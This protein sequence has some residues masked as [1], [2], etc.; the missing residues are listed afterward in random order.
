M[1]WYQAAVKGPSL[2][3]RFRHSATLVDPSHVYY[4]GGS[5][6]GVL[7]NDIAVLDLDQRSLALATSSP[8]PPLEPADV[9]ASPPYPHKGEPEF[10]EVV[11]VREPIGITTLDGMGEPPID[12]EKGEAETTAPSQ[13]PPSQFPALPNGQVPSVEEVMKMYVGMAMALRS[14]RQQRERMEMSL[15]K[16]ERAMFEDRLAREQ[17]EEKRATVEGE[18]L[19]V[20][21]AKQK[22]ENAK[23]KAEKSLKAERKKS[24]K[25]ERSKEATILAL[26]GE[27]AEEK[28]RLDGEYQAE[29]RKRKRAKAKLLKLKEE[30]QVKEAEI[31]KLRAEMGHSKRQSVSLL[32]SYAYFL[33]PANSLQSKN[34]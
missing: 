21:E 7:F 28:D 25:G 9:P 33:H 18:L 34:T 22:L 4:F 11:K 27:L 26:K 29:R 20:Q 10:V 24:K 3:P 16:L 14:E 13:I 17:I 31:Q 32:F 23:A 8:P 12:P 15:R 30:S 2:A 1:V 19:C 5:G 6:S